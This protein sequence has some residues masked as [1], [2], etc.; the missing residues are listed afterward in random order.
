MRFAT[1]AALGPGRVGATAWAAL[2]LRFAAE[3]GS[4]GL[5]AA[6]REGA[7]AAGLRWG[8][9]ALRAVTVC[10]VALRAGA[11]CEV[12][13]SLRLGPALGRFCAWVLEA[14]FAMGLSFDR[15]RGA[16]DSRRSGICA[17]SQ[18]RL[19]AS[20]PNPRNCAMLRWRDSERAHSTGKPSIAKCN[21]ATPHRLNLRPESQFVRLR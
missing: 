9:D 21:G 17:A 16:F 2:L 10:E 7:L 5:T 1:F 12:R 6:A 20:R 3:R 18:C 13:L 4:G 8:E 11:A 14:F 15:L 19:R